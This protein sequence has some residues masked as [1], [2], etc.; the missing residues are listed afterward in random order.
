ME[1]HTEQVEKY[2]ALV[3]THPEMDELRRKQCLCLNCT[4]TADC[5]I[6]HAGYELCKKYNVAY[7]MT[8][9][10]EFVKK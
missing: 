2:G 3:Y 5:E 4:K 1:F 7:A 9:C 10:P 8:R 6:A